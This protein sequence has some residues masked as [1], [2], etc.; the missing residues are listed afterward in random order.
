MIKS[1]LQSIVRPSEVRAMLHMK[2]NGELQTGD[3]STTWELRRDE[4][5]FCYYALKRVSRSFAAVIRQLP[6]DLEDAICV[7]YLVLRGLDSVEDDMNLDPV[8]KRKLLTDFHVNLGTGRNYPGIGDTDDYRALMARF[9]QV[10]A[11]FGQ[12]PQQHCDVIRRIC[13]Q[14]GLG[15]VEF[16]EK[17]VD[18]LSDYDHYCHIVAGLVG[19][20]LTELFAASGHEERELPDHLD[21]ANAMGLF[22]QKTN[23]TRDYHEDLIEGRVFWP[24]GIWRKH[25]ASI[26][27]F[28][29]DPYSSDARKALNE[30]VVDALRH[31]PD[32]VRYLGRLRHRAVFRFCAIPQA[33]A[34]A[35]LVKIY[36]NPEVFTS[37]VKIRKGLAARIMVETV[38][39][40]A[41][42]EL[43]L[44][45]LALLESKGLNSKAA[46]HVREARNSIALEK[47][48]GKNR[49]Q[50]YKQ[51]S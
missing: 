3:R 16:T 36:D 47:A 21:L 26:G 31:L 41:L 9:G 43:I 17:E 12:L 45:Q 13:R 8:G 10:D 1:L 19:L 37:K 27:T 14:M 20:G 34:I 11:F 23:I 15:M 22:L 40:D 50:W 6:S 30:M 24:S 44:G 25:A 7:F 2:W 29:Q 28:N 49:T 38:D 46:E 18:S 51:V 35:T 48:T 32:C 5:A 39:A 33:M 42:W 4:K